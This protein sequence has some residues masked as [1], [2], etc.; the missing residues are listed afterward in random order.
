MF[1]ASERYIPDRDNIEFEID[2]ANI[3]SDTDDPVKIFP[4]DLG[5]SEEV[6]NRISSNE[7]KA[8]KIDD[9]ENEFPEFLESLSDIY[10]CREKRLENGRLWARLARAGLNR[11]EF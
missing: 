5:A 8:R 7:V 1:L 11:N 6:M 10:D 3:F 9:F 4:L 2:A